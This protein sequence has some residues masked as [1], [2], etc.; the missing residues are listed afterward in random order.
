[1][2][3]VTLQSL[4][5]KSIRN[6]SEADWK[7]IYG[8]KGEEVTTM[9]HRDRAKLGDDFVLPRSGGIVAGEEEERRYEAVVEVLQ[10]MPEPDYSQLCDAI[11][12]FEWFIPP[13]WKRGEVI[14]FWSS[15]TATEGL[16]PHPRVI[17]LAPSLEDEQAVEWD[18]LIAIVAHELAHV[19]LNHSVMPSTQKYAVLEKEVEDRLVVWGF[20]KEQQAHKADKKRRGMI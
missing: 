14:G 15:F 12:T 20:E 18:V 8:R 6:I 3:A 5:I 19:V 17:Y 11:D 9:Y 4:T 16:K 1:M 7:V 10:R 13:L 2:R